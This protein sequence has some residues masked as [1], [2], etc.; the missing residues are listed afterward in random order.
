MSYDK[1]KRSASTQLRHK[2]FL[3][4][5]RIFPYPKTLATIT[6]VFA[7]TVL[8]FLECLVND[9]AFFTNQIFLSLIHVVAYISGSFDCTALIQCNPVCV[10]LY[11]LVN[12]RVVSTLGY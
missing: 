3:Q 2:T 11:Q 10:S 5:Q 1:Y 12:I 9:V 7:S 6:L 8:C 4:L